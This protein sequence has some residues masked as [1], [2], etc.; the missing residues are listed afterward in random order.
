VNG[1]SDGVG[2]ARGAS[3]GAGEQSYRSEERKAGHGA[4]LKE[5]DGRTG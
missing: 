4:E 5:E 3:L 2:T 1:V